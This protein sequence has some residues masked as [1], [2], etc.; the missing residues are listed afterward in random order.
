VLLSPYSTEVRYA[1]GQLWQPGV[2]VN[3]SAVLDVVEGPIDQPIT[4]YD[5]KFGS[6]TLSQTRIQQIQTTAGLGPGVP[7]LEVKP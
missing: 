2:S 1:N 5:Y 4:V 6:A 3:G 7:V